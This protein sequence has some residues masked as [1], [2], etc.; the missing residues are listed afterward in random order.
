MHKK[1]MPK[2][3]I[4]CAGEGTRLQP[5]TFNCPKCLV[6]IDGIALLDRQLEVLRKNNIEDITLVGGYLAD[7]LIK[8]NTSLI[9]NDRYSETNMVWSLFL[10]REKMNSD[11]IIAYGDIVYSTKILDK[12]I[13][14]PKDIVVAIDLGWESYWRKRADD[15]LSD[16][17]TLRLSNQNKILEIGNK[18]KS[19]KEIDGQYMG[20]MKFSKQGLVIM[21]DLFDELVSIGN[22]N[23]L[24]IEKAYM[25]DLL[26]E[27]IRRGISVHAVT[28]DDYWI[29]VDTV[30]D[31]ESEITKFRASKI[32]EE[33]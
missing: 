9:I 26:Q 29:E 6:P 28:V 17:E 21:K 14:S 25:T 4:L 33:M 2:A 12:V 24:S 30:E 11:A 1:I 32:Y 23:G 8:D 16:A 27:M 20:L 15:F 18:P 10:A 5:Y 31:L 22:I 19:I 13:N 7:L 3:I